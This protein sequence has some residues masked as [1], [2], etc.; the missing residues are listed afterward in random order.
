MGVLKFISTSTSAI[1]T[2]FEKSVKGYGV[3]TAMA[4]CK[5]SHLHFLLNILIKK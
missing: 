3:L 2:S 1:L 4:A 5:A